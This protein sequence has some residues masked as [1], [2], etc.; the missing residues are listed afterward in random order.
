MAKKKEVKKFKLNKW[1]KILLWI[2]GIFILLDVIYWVW[3]FV[4]WTKYTNQTHGYSVLYPPSWYVSNKVYI[5]EDPVMISADPNL[6]SQDP[7]SDKLP[8]F[9]VG[10]VVKKDEDRNIEKTLDFY[11]K[12]KISFINMKDKKIGGFNALRTNYIRI[13][14]FDGYRYI[15]FI[16]S[17]DI[18]RNDLYI[19]LNA[20]LA[21]SF[22][23]KVN[24]TN[25]AHYLSVRRMVDSVTFETSR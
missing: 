10:I 3:P 25:I 12:D 4:F 16:E 11:N 17:L 20:S 5:G 2:V 21:C 1:V 15:D 24:M 19:H 8:G 18:E 23:C 9:F 7:V 6:S 14:L 13:K 22:N